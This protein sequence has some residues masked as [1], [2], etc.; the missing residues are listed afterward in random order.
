MKIYIKY[1][2]SVPELQI[3]DRGEWID[4]CAAQSVTLEGPTKTKSSEI[5]F[6]SNYI[7]LGVA[8]KLPKGFEAHIVPRSS[9]F[10]KKGVIL[11]N[12]IGII[13]NAYCGN[14]DTWRALLIALR[15]TEI[16][17]GERLLQFRIALSQKATILQKLRWL[18]TRKIKFIKVNT[19][20]DS[21]RGGFGSTN[22][23]KVLQKNVNQ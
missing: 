10:S 17:K 18:F 11:S 8:M 3:S 20:S 19:L 22:G 1:H 2:N 7:S 5:Q 14:D 6:Q 9:L 13:D 21:N 4:L 16:I 12:S 23:Y 15:S